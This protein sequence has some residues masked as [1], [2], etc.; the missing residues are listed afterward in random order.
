MR[1][2]LLNNIIKNIRRLFRNREVI[3]KTQRVRLKKP[4][5]IEITRKVVEEE[6]KEE[7]LKS[8]LNS[9]I[10]DLKDQLNSFNNL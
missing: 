8:S 9:K 2:S 3:T 4:T 10:K 7:Q 1:S 5:L 6:I